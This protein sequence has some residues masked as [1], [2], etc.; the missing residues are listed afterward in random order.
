M[1]KEALHFRMRYTKENSVDLLS[2]PIILLHAPA[3]KKKINT[4][5]VTL[6]FVKSASIF[7]AK[8][9]CSGNKFYRRW[10]VCYYHILNQIW[11]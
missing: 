11:T 3:S 10:L 4:K 2:V 8:T 1:A 9:K 5:S 7:I 6:D